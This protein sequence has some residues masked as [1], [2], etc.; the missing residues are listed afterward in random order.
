MNKSVHILFPKS[1][2]CFSRS[3]TTEV[4]T[5]LDSAAKDFKITQ[6]SDW[7]NLTTKVKALS[8]QTHHKGLQTH[9][10][11]SIRRL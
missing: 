6:V 5:T 3:F 11:K 1:L 2:K 4:R 9:P 10:W 7:Y 8:F